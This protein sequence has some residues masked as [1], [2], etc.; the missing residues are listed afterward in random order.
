MLN[1]LKT[2]IKHCIII[3]FALIC[4]GV[5]FACDRSNPNTS[6]PL[7]AGDIIAA[8]QKEITALETKEIMDSGEPYILIDVRTKEEYTE[9]HIINAILLPVSEIA[10][11]A[12]TELPDK[13]ALIIMYCRYGVRSANAA[14]IL[15]GMGYT[16]VYNLGAITDWPYAT[17]SGP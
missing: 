14:E 11:R 13:S 7:D 15:T 5:L 6:P 17:M 9:E 16:E 2:R 1:R 8:E 12:E 10:E 3:C 4:L